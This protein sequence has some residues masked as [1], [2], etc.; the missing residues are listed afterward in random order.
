MS[1]TS[2][3][4]LL[5][6]IVVSFLASSSAPTPIYAIYA[7]EMHFS[8]ITTTI[9][10]GTYAITVLVTLLVL[11]RLSDHLGRKPVLLAA[12]ALQ[13]V[14]M[15]V[16]VAADGVG[17]LL[18]GRV[19]QGIA[20]GGALGALGAAMLDIDRDR[21]TSANAVG[22]PLGTGAGSLLSGL[23]VQYLP[24]PTQLVYLVLILVFAAQA[25]GVARLPETGE[26]KPGVRAAL[27]PQLAVP[28][29]L[30][31]SMLAVAPVLF[32]TWSL[33]GFYGALAPSLARQ[34]SGSDS[35]VIG[36]L[37]LFVLAVVAAGT[38]VALSRRPPRTVMF[39]GITMLVVSSLGTLAVV[40]L[41]SVV[42]FFVFTFLAGIGF[43]AG[44]QG[45]MR[46]VVPQ[47]R[48]HERAGVLSTVYVICYLGMGLPAVV[49]GILVVH[50]GGLIAATVDYS[51]FVAV[52]A[53]V[54]LVALIRV[55]PSAPS[56]L[57]LVESAA[58]SQGS[59]CTGS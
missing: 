35:L 54:T 44:F 1:T 30:R 19:L 48:E 42:G 21:G 41:S 17:L 24:A 49:A 39:L 37:G 11:G 31:R 25:V 8:P 52:F 47:A 14:A 45:G 51:L 58:A 50:G 26:R 16:F 27:V 43:G 12:L 18:L 28:R 23:I 38:T 10:F 5:A 36:G 9:I 34:L 15:A 4:A 22:T 13:I 46:T 53:V 40:E 29:H 6:S 7:G 55:R 57:A 59:C 33:G 32:A 2:R 56:R 3:L 20:T